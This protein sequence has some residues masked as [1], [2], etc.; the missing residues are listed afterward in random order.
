MEKLISSFV[1]ITWVMANLYDMAISQGY[2]TGLLNDL[3]NSFTKNKEYG[4]ESILM[5]NTRVV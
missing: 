3:T 2:L 5:I 1:G 4:D